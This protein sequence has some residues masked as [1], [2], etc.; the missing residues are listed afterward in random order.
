MEASAASH[1][2]RRTAGLGS[3]SPALAHGA[4]EAHVGAQRPRCG[5]FLW[6]GAG[7]AGGLSAR[8]ARGLELRGPQ[9]GPVGHRQPFLSPQ[10]TV[11]ELSYL[12]VICVFA[13][14]AGH[15]TG[16]SEYPHAPPAQSSSASVRRVIAARDLVLL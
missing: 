5:S 7:S 12:G 2:A 14:I 9:P 11:P 8:G 6:R 15:S 13:Y 1:L 10:G 16:P 3:S 4:L